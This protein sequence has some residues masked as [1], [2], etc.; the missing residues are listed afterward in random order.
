MI[1]DFYFRSVFYSLDF[2]FYI[3]CY[4]YTMKPFM[5][6]DVIFL[7]HLSFQ[8]TV[9]CR[10]DNFDLDLEDIMVMEAIWLSIQ[11]IR[12]WYIEYNET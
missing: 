2:F 12:S 9:K 4:I 6:L 8:H 5:I 1:Y 10:D 3:S 7:Y 11:V